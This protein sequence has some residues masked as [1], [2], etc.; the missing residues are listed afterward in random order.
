MTHTY[1]TTASDLTRRLPEPLRDKAT[2]ASSNLAKWATAVHD[3]MFAEWNDAMAFIDVQ[4]PLDVATGIS[5]RNRTRFWR[6]PD[7]DVDAKARYYL[8][9]ELW[10]RWGIKTPAELRFA[11]SRIFDTSESAFTITENEDPATGDRDPFTY[12]IALDPTLFDQFGFA[13]SERSAAAQALED[14]LNE[15]APVGASMQ[16]T[17]PSGAAYGTAVYGTDTYA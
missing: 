6:S 13:S 5:L 15:I 16:V 8:S 10:C 3:A 2:D 17:L 11:L 1:G 12:F 9:V 14:C 7:D 4:W